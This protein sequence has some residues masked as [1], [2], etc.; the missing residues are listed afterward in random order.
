MS[1]SH[2]CVTE[3]TLCPRW[4][5]KRG[6]KMEEVLTIESRGKDE[7]VSGCAQDKG[8]DLRKTKF[9]WKYADDVKHDA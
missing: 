3:P 9:R 4:H 7:R 5:L 6:R 1:H 2:P 8:D